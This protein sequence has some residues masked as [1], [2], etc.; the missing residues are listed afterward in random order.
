ML[1]RSHFLAL[2]HLPT[3][4]FYRVLH[5]QHQPP[6]PTPCS[7]LPLPMPLPSPFCL[8]PSIT[9]SPDSNLLPQMRTCSWTIKMGA[10]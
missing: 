10:T 9:K 1:T 8:S 7:Q 4:S 2:T 3:F 6:N 5:S